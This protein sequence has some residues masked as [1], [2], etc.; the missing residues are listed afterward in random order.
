MQATLAEAY[1][2]DPC[3]ENMHRAMKFALQATADQWFYS[4]RTAL[5]THVRDRYASEVAC[6]YLATG[7]DAIDIEEIAKAWVENYL[8]ERNME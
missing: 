7:F 6:L 8:T 5:R 2:E 3:E 4:A 1:E